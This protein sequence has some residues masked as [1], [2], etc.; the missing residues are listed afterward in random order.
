MYTKGDFHMHTI[1]SDGDYTP[2]EVVL[3]GKEKGLDIM[4]ITDHNTMNGVEEAIAVGKMVDIKVIPGIEVSTRHKGK[5]VHVLGY[6]NNDKY[7]N[8]AF[9]KALRY[10][11]SHDMKGLKTL[12]GNEFSLDFDYMHK[13]ICTKTG[14]ELI[15]YF[16]GVA[17]LAH[18]VKIKPYI[19]DEVLEMNLDGV[20]AIYWKNT[21]EETEYFK[22]I[23]KLKNC[24]YTAG[25]DFH[26]DKSLDRR[27]GMVG[28]VFLN[29]DEI[30][31]FINGMI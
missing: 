2:T 20:E 8:E 28:D 5:K 4:A 9:Q 31:K 30:E 15:K 3:M 13:R 10:M 26:T 18:P 1:N 21:E 24:F 17:V 27:H 11:K 29:Q 7:K 25:S 14:I 19:L 16:G 22:N 12:V 23:A 6:F